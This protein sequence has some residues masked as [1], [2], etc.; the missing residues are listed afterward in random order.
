MREPTE[1]PAP[2]L[3]AVIEH[4]GA[5]DVRWVLTGSFV[6]AACGAAI[7]PNDV[8]VTPDLDTENLGRLARALQAIDAIPAHFPGSPTTLSI[9]ECRAWL[10]TPTEGGLDHLFVTSLGM[11]D[12]VPRLCGLYDDLIASSVTAEIVGARVAVCDPALVLRLTEGRTRAKDLARASAY[13][14]LR[15][16]PDLAVRTDILARLAAM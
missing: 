9:E 3:G 15:E 7:A 14:A 12:V 16:Q 6:L 11:V 1:R 8:D 2:Q 13:A 4:L 10:A 5:H